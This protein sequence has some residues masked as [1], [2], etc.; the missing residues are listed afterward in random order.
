MLDTQ[1][2]RDKFMLSANIVVQRYLGE[3][4]KGGTVR[5]RGRLAITE[6]GGNDDEVLIRG[7]IMRLESKFMTPDAL[8]VGVG[9]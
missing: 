9:R 4:L 2:L 6:E 3:W 1:V 8:K 5:R 7:Q